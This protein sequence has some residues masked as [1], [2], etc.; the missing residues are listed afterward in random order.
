MKVVS[1]LEELSQA[2]GPSPGTVVTIGVF[3]GLH[4]GHQLL[5]RK[6]VELGRARGLASLVITF[7]E[8]PLRVLA[9]PYAPR[10]L[11]YPV[12]KHRMLSQLGVDLVWSVTFTAKF[13]GQSPGQFVTDVLCGRCGMRVLVCGYDFSFGRAGAGNV[14]L[15]RQLSRQLGFDLEVVE[16][17]SEHSVAVKSTQVRDLVFAGRVDEVAHLLAQPFELQGEVVTGF[18]R[19]KG[20]GFPTANLSVSADY[21][22]PARGVYFCLANVMGTPE[23]VPAMVNIGY[24]PTFGADRLSVEAH[25]IG[26]SGDLVGQTVSLFFLKRLRDERK[27]PDVAALVEQLHTDKRLCLALAAEPQTASEMERVRAIV[28]G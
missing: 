16:P 11:M 22:L 2:L 8:H 17:V 14:G 21:C 19:G 3:D 18:G 24:N 13:A 4:G 1:T 27:F 10:K 5:V 7:A 15:L 20:I 26:F 6:S 25:L 23:I 9:P 28:A 12:R